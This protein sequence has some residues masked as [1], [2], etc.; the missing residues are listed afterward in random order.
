MIEGIAKSIPEAAAIQNFVT[1]LPNLDRM[2]GSS[3][4][5]YVGRLRLRS[6]PRSG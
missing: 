4:L 6:S 2:G 3:P 1:Y 5:R